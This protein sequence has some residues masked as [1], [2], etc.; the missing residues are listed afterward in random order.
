MGPFVGAEYGR[1]SVE[2]GVFLG[3]SEMAGGCE[4]GCSSVGVTTRILVGPLVPV[5]GSGDGCLSVAVVVLPGD[6]AL[7]GR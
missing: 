3:P 1:S 4:D 7:V 6:G 2:G 5:G